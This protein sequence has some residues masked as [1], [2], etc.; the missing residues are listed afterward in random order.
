MSRPEAPFNI[1]AI[2]RELTFRSSLVAHAI[3][4][5]INDDRFKSRAFTKY[6]ETNDFGLYTQYTIDHTVSDGPLIQAIFGEKADSLSIKKDNRSWDYLFDPKPPAAQKNLRAKSSTR[7]AWPPSPEPLNLALNRKPKLYGEFNTL[8]SFTYLDSREHH[9]N[10]LPLIH[11]IELEFG[12]Q[13]RASTTHYLNLNDL[14]LLVT[15]ASERSGELEQDSTTLKLPLGPGT[16]DLR[17]LPNN[18]WYR[19]DNQSPDV[20][21][22]Q[23]S[24]HDY[25]ELEIVNEFGAAKV[26]LAMDPKQTTIGALNLSNPG[27]TSA[28]EMAAEAGLVEDLTLNYPGVDQREI[29]AAMI[30]GYRELYARALYMGM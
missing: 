23:V 8:R 22:V 30:W 17:L 7:D 13:A 6:F 24:T 26:T 12:D 10:T 4:Q 15:C 21:G 9:S 16:L 2:N 5:V 20:R 29:T 25:R 3:Y 14:K 18:R 27:I 19:L 28:N 1:L 11:Q